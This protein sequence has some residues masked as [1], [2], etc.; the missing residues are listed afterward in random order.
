MTVVIGPGPAAAASTFLGYDPEYAR[1]PEVVTIPP[2]PTR[3]GLH[4][5]QLSPFPGKSSAY[6]L[7][8]PHYSPS[9]ADETTSIRR[10]APV[11]PE[12]SVIVGEPGRSRSPSPRNASEAEDRRERIFRENEEARER[13][14]DEAEVRRAEEAA[15]RRN[16]IWA[17]L[18]DRLQVLPP[19]TVAA[20]PRSETGSIHSIAESMTSVHT[21]PISPTIPVTPGIPGPPLPVTESAAGSEPV[22][23]YEDA[24][25][26]Q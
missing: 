2:S 23:V 11:T 15:H 14:F 24:S 26:V 18:E 21:P 13:I 16:Q 1:R 6:I 10:S 8:A 22:L 20:V 17:D 4:I 5:C 9:E 12:D 19:V 25:S 7:L 3:T